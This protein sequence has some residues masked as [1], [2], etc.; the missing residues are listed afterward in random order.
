MTEMP[1]SDPLKS[2]EAQV[3][4]TQKLFDVYDRRTADSKPAFNCGAGG[5]ISIRARPI[6]N[7]ARCDR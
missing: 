3:R 6:L 5:A 4:L 7:R 2:L 1:V